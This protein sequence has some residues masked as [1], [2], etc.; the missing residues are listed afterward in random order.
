M[1][2]RLWFDHAEIGE[3]ETVVLRMGD[4]GT[5]A[6][7]FMQDKSY[8]VA[9]EDFIQGWV[10]TFVP[11]FQEGHTS[12]ILSFTY[13]VDYAGFVMFTTATSMGITADTAL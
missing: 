2:G 4:I 11:V 7:A 3:E 8:F 6:I 9:N 13:S 1:L 5:G 10:G 12:T